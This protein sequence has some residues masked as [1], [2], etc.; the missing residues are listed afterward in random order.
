[1]EDE[2]VNL[3][4]AVGRMTDRATTAPFKASVRRRPALHRRNS[5]C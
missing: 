3:Y 5:V 2:R 4:A 1:V